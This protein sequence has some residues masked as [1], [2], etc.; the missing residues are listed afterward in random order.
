[1]EFV[2]IVEVQLLEI[3]MDTGSNILLIIC[4]KRWNTRVIESP[5]LPEESSMDLA[6]HGKKAMSMLSKF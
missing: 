3:F 4:L 5:L 2:K 6:S 1:M